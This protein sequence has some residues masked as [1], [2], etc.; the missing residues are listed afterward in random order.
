MDKRT[1]SNSMYVYFNYKNSNITII[2]IYA[3]SGRLL[4]HKLIELE[5]VVL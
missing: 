5:D 2:N 1:G 3:P 4:K